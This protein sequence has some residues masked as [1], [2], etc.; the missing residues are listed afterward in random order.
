VQ[1]TLTLTLTPS[2]NG[3]PVPAGTVDFYDGNVQIC[4]A[5]PLVPVQVGKNPVKAT[6]L[7]SFSIY[8]TRAI[9]AVYAGDVVYNPAGDTLTETVKTPNGTTTGPIT[10]TTT[11]KVDLAGP[12]SGPYA[13][14]TLFQERGSN[15]TVTLAPGDS[16]AGNCP[17]NFLTKG[18]PPDPGKTPDACGD[19]GGLQGTV[20]APNPDALV[21]IESAGMANLQVIAGKIEVDNGANSRF[22]FDASKFANSSIHLVE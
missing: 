16:S 21:L 22:G 14:L 2:S 9:S 19:I 15:L 11:G 17:G 4:S 6:C 12:T 13:G 1:I 20:Y 3:S 10:I 18:V 5:S 8:G 7:T